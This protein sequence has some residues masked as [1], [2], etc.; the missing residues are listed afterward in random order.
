MKCKNCKSPIAKGTKFCGVC[1]TQ[2]KKKPFILRPAFFVPTLIVLLVLVIGGSLAFFINA[3]SD[4]SKTAR[5][6]HSNRTERTEHTRR[7]T[8]DDDD[9]TPTPGPTDTPTPVPVETAYRTVMVYIIGSNLETNS[10]LASS[11]IDEMLASD[12]GDNTNIVIQTG[13]AINWTNPLIDDGEVNRFEIVNGTLN[14]TADLGAMSMVETSSLQDFIE[15]S[16]ENYPANNYTLV[17]YN[18]GGGVPI[19]FGYD[20]IYDGTLTDINIGDALDGAGIH[21]DALIFNACDMC[22]LE[23]LMSVQDNTDYVLASERTL[24]G[25]D[26]YGAGIDY[27][28][29]LPLAADP[30]VSIE[31]V[32]NVIADDY[33]EFLNMINCP[34]SMSIVRT[35]GVQAVYDAYVDYIGDI[36]DNYGPETYVNYMAARKFS[37]TYEGTDG[38]DLYTM[39]ENFSNVYTPSVQ[40]AINGAVLRVASTLDTDYG[41]T[42]Y[43]IYDHFDYYNEG[44]ES[45]VSLNY[46]DKVIGFYDLIAARM[47]FYAGFENFAG[48]WYIEP[49]D[50][51]GDYG[52][53]I[54][55]PSA[56]GPGNYTV[57]LSDDL[58]RTLSSVEMW[59]IYDADNPRMRYVYG[60]DR[61]CELDYNNDLVVAAPRYWLHVN[62][63]VPTTMVMER[64]FE[65]DGGFFQINFVYALVNGEESFLRLECGSDNAG[66]FVGYYPANFAATRMEGSLR[67][68]LPTD[69]VQFVVLAIH[70]DGTMAYETYDSVFTADT[71]DIQWIAT[72]VDR[73][74]GE[75][76]LY[77][78][79][80]DIYGNEY[81]TDFFYLD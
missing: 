18:H 55:L 17:M 64:I 9:P 34:G 14:K 61:Q 46:D 44:R 51:Y 73:T 53:S 26:V 59:F 43:S 27:T 20:E 54:S 21:F 67:P 39:A 7:T 2:V 6:H 72:D 10:G 42:V 45:L 62:D 24:Y 47:F 52:Q 48:D 19:A 22:S 68:L 81:T 57:P 23:L 16:A 29:W 5:R 70:P 78:V 71:L 69:E 32:C 12:I 40:S 33:I 58:Y 41:I 65:Q 80:Q 76:V 4:D 15:Y 79:L 50:L 11:D 66:S 13:G 56:G 37:V 1:G 74:Q 63:V 36:Y 8:S 35:S 31:A 77:Y 28:A 49:D 3:A 75:I 38:V 25:Y 60:T 30:T